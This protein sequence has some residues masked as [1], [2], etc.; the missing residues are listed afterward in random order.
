M[1][2]SIAIKSGTGRHGGGGGGAAGAPPEDALD[3]SCKA[4]CSGTDRSETVDLD[5]FL[6]RLD[7][8]HDEACSNTAAGC[9]T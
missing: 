6:L 4:S 5:L 3:V 2:W 9:R 7:H 1:T 8:A